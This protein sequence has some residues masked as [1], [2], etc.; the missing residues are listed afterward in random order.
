MVHAGPNTHDGGL[1]VGLLSVAYQVFTDEEVKNPAIAPT[2]MGM[3]IEIINLRVRFMIN[4]LKNFVPLPFQKMTPAIHTTNVPVC[5]KN[6]EGDS[7]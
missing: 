6:K 7:I 1:K 5:T 4:F 2:V 3:A